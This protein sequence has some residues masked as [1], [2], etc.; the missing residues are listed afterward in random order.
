MRKAVVVA[1]AEAASRNRLYHFA[2]HR[3]LDK[4][5]QGGKEC[6]EGDS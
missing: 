2:P 1:V 3:I 5:G 4:L 6:D